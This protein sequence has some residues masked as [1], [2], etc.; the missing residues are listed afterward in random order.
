MVRETSSSIWDQAESE[1]GASSRCRLFMGI[2]SFE[3]TDTEGT[4][5]GWWWGSGGFI[6]GRECRGLG[7][8]DVVEKGGGGNE[9]QISGHCGAEVQDAIVVAGWSADE[10]VLE[11]LF[12]GSW[13][14][15]VTDEIGAEFATAGTTEWHVVA[16]NFDFLPVFFDYRQRIVR[17]GGFYGVV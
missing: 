4:I 11:H 9:K 2:F 17:R 10:H 6:W 8:R 13:R 12:D 16:E 5:L 15:A 1:T 3:G 7:G 14:A